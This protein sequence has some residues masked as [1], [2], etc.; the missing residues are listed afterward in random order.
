VKSILDKSFK[1]TDS[2]STDIRKLFARIRKE[3]T[4][5][6]RE[7]AEKVKPMRKANGMG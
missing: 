4:A 3:Q 7:Q 1:Y 6:K 5:V 2:T